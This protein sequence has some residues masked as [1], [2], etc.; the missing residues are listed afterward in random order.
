MNGIGEN[1]LIA[2]LAGLAT[3]ITTAWLV[4]DA[5]AAVGRERS[6]LDIPRST[7]KRSGPK[8]RMD[9]CIQYVQSSL[10]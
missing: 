2:Y 1:K 4:P 6:V 5:L 7:F 10:I 3:L 9:A 8:P